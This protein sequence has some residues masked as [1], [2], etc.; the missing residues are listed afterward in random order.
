MASGRLPVMKHSLLLTIGI[1]LCCC[2]QPAPE[3]PGWTPLFDG[4]TLEGWQ[5]TN[6]GGEGAVSVSDGS[7]ILSYG[8]DLTGV[9][10][11][12]DVQTDDYEISLE[13]KK[14]QGN[15]FFCGLTFP[16]GDSQVSLIVGGWGGA[17][18]GIS[19]ID[20]MDASENETTTIMGFENDRWYRIQVKV[21]K[22]RIE[23]FIDGRSV[24]DI[25]TS[26]RALTVRPEVRLSRPLGIATW[27]TSAALRDIR[28]RPIG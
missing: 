11:T 7:I 27:R 18:V 10:W 28:V 5:I 19:S 12:G 24:G 2:A 15:D 16:V 20:G 17:V 6:F 9:T 26:G 23:A 4:L 14:L 13:A 25:E 21:V 1:C 3:H 22:G 8:E